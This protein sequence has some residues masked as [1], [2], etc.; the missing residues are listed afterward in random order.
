MERIC[1]LKND[2]TWAENNPGAAFFAW[3]IIAF[4]DTV[5]VVWRLLLS[6]EGALVAQINDLHF[7]ENYV[8]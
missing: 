8:Y 6:N 5:Y 4:R 7:W 2:P 1:A 3:N